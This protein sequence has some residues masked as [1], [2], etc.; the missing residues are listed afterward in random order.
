MNNTAEL[1][2]QMLARADADAL[3]ADHELRVKAQAFDQAAVGFYAQPQTTDVRTFMG[4]WARARRCWSD[5]TGE[6]LL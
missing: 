2:R 4:H 1:T 6:P 5:Y 3:P